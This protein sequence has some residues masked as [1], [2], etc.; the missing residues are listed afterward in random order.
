M[1]KKSFLHTMNALRLMQ[2][3][4]ITLLFAAFLFFAVN[5]TQKSQQDNLQNYLTIFTRELD[6]QFARVNECLSEIV[7]NNSDLEIIRSEDAETRQYAAIRLLDSIQSAMKTV[8]GADI[9]TVAVSTNGFYLEDH[10]QS[11]T[12]KQQMYFREFSMDYA[13]NGRQTGTWNLETIGANTYVYR[14]MLHNNRSVI[15]FISLDSLLHTLYGQLPEGQCYLLADPEG[16]VLTGTGENWQQFSGCN[17]ESLPGFWNISRSTPLTNR[18]LLLCVCENSAQVLRQIQSAFI[19]LFALI[20][21]VWLFSINYSSIIQKKLLVPMQKMTEDM[22]YIQSGELER[23]ISTQS[24][25]IE[26]QTLVTTFN[27]LIEKILQLKIQNYERKLAFLDAEQKYTR[28]QIRPHF[29]LNAMT[30]IVG[31]SRSGKNEDIETYISA[32]SKHIRYLFSSGLYTVPAGDELRHLENYF[33]MQE[34]K[35][36]DAVLYFIDAPEE[37][38]QWQIP[39]MLIHTIVENEYKYALDGDEQL[40]ILIRLGIEEFDGQKMLVIEIEDNGNGYPIDVIERIN[41]P[42][43]QRTDDGTRVGLWSIRRLMELMYDQQGLFTLE[44][45]E[46][47]GALSRIRVPAQAVRQ[48]SNRKEQV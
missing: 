10:N 38:R 14:A 29:F 30:T 28:L 15:A 21:L 26:F 8:G 12:V 6:N 46:P 45:V 36:P 35:Y 39:Q 48:R 13:Q 42:S 44:N 9:I 1:K 31:L 25:A 47:H 3:G 20:L 19:L 34:L 16:N 5:S 24:D 7:Y 41:A 37:V 23:K 32:L 43:A 18:V 4:L 11:V 2:L 27:T 17:L 40:M 22:R 33:S